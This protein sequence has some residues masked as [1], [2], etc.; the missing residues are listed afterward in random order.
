MVEAENGNYIPIEYLSI[1]TVEQLYLSLRL[2]AQAEGISKEILPIMLDE[3]FSYYDEERLRNILEFLN[4]EYIDRQILIFTC[5]D[6]EKNIL[7]K[8]NISYNLIEL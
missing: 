7:D 4:K 5:T 3:A 2:S 6:R 8:S 1:G